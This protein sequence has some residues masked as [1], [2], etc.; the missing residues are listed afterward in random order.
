MSS[1]TSTKSVSSSIRQPTP[2]FSD[3]AS[4][5]QSQVEHIEEI[6]QQYIINEP[7][8]DDSSDCEEDQEETFLGDI[9][10]I[11]EAIK[12]TLSKIQNGAHK[13][14]QDSNRFCKS[15]S[16]CTKEDVV[17]EQAQMLVQSY[18]DV[19]HCYVQLSEIHKKIISA[20]LV[21]PPEITNDNEEE[22]SDEE[23]SNSI[24]IKKAQWEGA[25]AVLKIFTK[26]IATVRQ[27]Y[28]S[29]LL[30]L[31][32]DSNETVRSFLY[33]V[34][35]DHLKDCSAISKMY[36][37]TILEQA[38]DIAQ[39]QND[40]QETHNY[41]PEDL[42]PFIH[43][44]SHSVYDVELNL[45][46][47]NDYDVVDYFRK[48]SA[49]L[50]KISQAIEE[51]NEIKYTLLQPILQKMQPYFLRSILASLQESATWY[52]SF[53]AENSKAIKRMS[54]EQ[55]DIFYEQAHDFKAHADDR[56][57]E[58]MSIFQDF[59]EAASVTVV[60]MA[61][62]YDLIVSIG[63]LNSNDSENEAPSIEDSLIQR[64][65]DELSN[66]S[67]IQDTIIEK[68]EGSLDEEEDGENNESVETLLDNHQKSTQDLLNALR[69][70]IKAFY[71]ES[72]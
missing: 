12:K 17:S 53:V 11:P 58:L 67:Q 14:V 24:N 33:S 54:K 41:F 22:E 32:N 68:F 72:L 25:G 35:E 64:I 4:K 48:L 60:E 8:N 39:S 55:Q 57:D 37:E 49:L 34:V 71:S 43:S 42:S 38:N 31:Y 69:I 15:L 19:N 13:F 66:I 46:E 52:E 44:I 59:L 23:K 70:A 29:D 3:Q 56:T 62:L 40:N 36:F 16:R 7:T 63:L 1:V 47:R 6:F 65:G 61:K 28:I 18:D 26:Q 30:S 45:F 27:T 5:L 10:K 2:P 9:K 51:E 20:T 50:T 21:L